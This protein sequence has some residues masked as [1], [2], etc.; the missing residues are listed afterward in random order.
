MLKFE[1]IVSRS[2]GCQESVP[3][4]HQELQTMV[5]FSYTSIDLVDY[6]SLCMY[7]VHSTEGALLFSFSTSCSDVEVFNSLTW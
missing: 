6:L 1:V 3:Q 2:R 4:V 7:S 5:Y